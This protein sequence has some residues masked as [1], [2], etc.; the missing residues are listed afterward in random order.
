MQ[1]KLFKK[2]FDKKKT[3]EGRKRMRYWVKWL[4]S[5]FH[6]WKYWLVRQ[7]HR[8]RA[9]MNRDH[10]WDTWAWGQYHLFKSYFNRTKVK[11][12]HLH[13]LNHQW[14][15]WIWGQLVYWNLLE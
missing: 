5:R 1:Y 6:K 13:R 7:K 14:E 10:W 2:K 8:S 3:P 15:R 11:T 12:R 9:V 4:W